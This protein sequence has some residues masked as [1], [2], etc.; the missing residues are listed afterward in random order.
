MSLQDR[1]LLGFLLAAV[2]AELARRAR[3]LSASGAVAA[4]LA[5][6]V[7]CAVGWTWALVLLAFFVTS[8]LL[9]RWRTAFK[10]R[11]TGALVAKGGPR[12]A[13]QVLSNGGVYT[14]AAIATLA[15]P[16]ADW[17]LAGLGALA[18]MTADT[19]STEIGIALGGTPRLLGRWRRV[20]PGTSGA[21]SVA[22]TVALLAGAIFLGL[23]ALIVHFPVPSVEPAVLGG[24]FGALVDTMLGATMQERRWCP[25]CAQQTEQSIH[26][27]GATTERASGV[28][29][30]DNDIVNLTSSVAGAALAVAAGRWI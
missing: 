20:P 27:C 26:A 4:T 15:Y 11:A 5:G 16:T 18:T 10:A 30:M 17:A 14:V 28:S 25:R 22:G 8:S 29:W 12:D 3:A 7:A 9:S 2:I 24:A 13:W 23:V 1:L 6:T 19:W 21:V